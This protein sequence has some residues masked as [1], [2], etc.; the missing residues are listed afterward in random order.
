M[1]RPANVASL[2]SSK[3]GEVGGRVSKAISEGVGVILNATKRDFRGS[4]AIFFLEGVAPPLLTYVYKVGDARCDRDV[5]S[6]GGCYCM[7]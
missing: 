7:A 1:S 2:K 6:G 4:H 5:R 3:S